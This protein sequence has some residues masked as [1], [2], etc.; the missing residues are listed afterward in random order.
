MGYDLIY[1]LSVF[2]TSLAVFSP[3]KAVVQY[4]CTCSLHQSLTSWVYATQFD[5]D[6]END[7]RQTRLR[8]WVADNSKNAPSWY[9]GSMLV[10]S[11]KIRG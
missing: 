3:R 1:P 2:N 8:E 7:Q 9:H 11:P 6:I 4:M 5:P 10:T